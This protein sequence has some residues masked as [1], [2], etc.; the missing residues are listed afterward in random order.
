MGDAA[1]ELD[2]LEPAA[3][4]ALGIVEGLAV[5]ERH[6]AGEIV[7]ALLDQALE[8]EHHALAAER[9]RR[10]PG[11]LRLLRDRHGVV[12]LG[13]GGEGHHR[14]HL[15]GRRVG[16]VALPAARARHPLVADEMSDPGDHLTS[17]DRFRAF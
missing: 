14:R 13:F 1:G 12:D 8:V 3:D 10:G 5:L 16:D 17:S 7:G 6:Q 2:H 9:R 15:A 11:R 4:L